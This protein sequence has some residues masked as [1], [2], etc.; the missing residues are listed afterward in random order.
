MNYSQEFISNKLLNFNSFI[1]YWEKSNDSQKQYTIFVLNDSNFSRNASITDIV[2][3]IIA[4]TKNNNSFFILSDL[5][6]KK[7]NF[8]FFNP[9]YF[10]ENLTPFYDELYITLEYQN[11]KQ[12]IHE[13]LSV[14]SAKQKEKS[15]VIETY[16]IRD[17]IKIPIGST[18]NNKKPHYFT[19]GHDTD[20]YNAIIGG[21]P[22]K[23]KSNLLRTIINRGKREL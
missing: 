9:E 16:D 3:R 17:G 6:S 11:L 7:E 12:R 15:G 1:D 18:V 5:D 20:S 2:N 8:A 14:I 23:G 13:N 19:F 22:G 10:I 21:Q 4:N